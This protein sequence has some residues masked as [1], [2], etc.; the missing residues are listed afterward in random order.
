VIDLTADGVGPGGTAVAQ[1]GRVRLRLVVR[2][3]PW[4]DV[5]EAEVLVGEH[6]GRARWISIPE[7]QDVVRL[8][9]TVDLAVSAPTFVVVFVRGRR[10]LPHLY[11]ENVPPAAFTNP[12]W[13]VP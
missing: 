7:S 3:A 13:L 4:I 10:P 8:D 2:A 1:D 9:Q 11:M 6:A 12:I 5:S